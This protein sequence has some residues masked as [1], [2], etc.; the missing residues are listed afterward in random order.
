MKNAEILATKV[1]LKALSICSDGFTAAALASQLEISLCSVWSESQTLDL[2]TGLERRGLLA[3]WEHPVTEQ[4]FYILTGA[5]RAALAVSW[6]ER[7]TAEA[8]ED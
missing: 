1:V 8:S 4:K 5:G 2:L 7:G 3:H 6:Q